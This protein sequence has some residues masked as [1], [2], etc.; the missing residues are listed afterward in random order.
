MTQKSCA[1]GMRNARPGN[2]LQPGTRSVHH[3]RYKMPSIE[4]SLGSSLFLSK[5]KYPH[6]QP[7]KVAKR[8][9]LGT[10]IGSHIVLTL[11][12]R[13]AA[14][15]GPWIRQ[16]L[17]ILVLIKTGPAKKR[18]S[19]QQHSRCQLVSFVAYISGASLKNTTSIFSEIFFIQYFI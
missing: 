10:D 17:G 11:I 9:L 16:K 13:L 4:N 7:L 3:K 12:I 6:F 1:I 8:V 14:V 5:T 2:H 15:D 19:W 18:L